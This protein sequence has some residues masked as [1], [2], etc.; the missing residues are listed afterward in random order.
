[1]AMDIFITIDEQGWCHHFRTNYRGWLWK[2]SVWLLRILRQCKYISV[3]NT[4][5]IADGKKIHKII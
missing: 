4:Y 5:G 3:I 1:M 2:P